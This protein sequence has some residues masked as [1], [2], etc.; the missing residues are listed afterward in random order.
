M[1][2]AESVR[3]AGYNFRSQ[4]SEDYG[5][6]GCKLLKQERVSSYVRKLR[7][8][9]FAKDALS[10]A[11]KRAFLARAVRS[12]ASNPD[13]DLVQE[14]VETHGEHGSSK[15]VKIVSK[16]EALNIDNK[17][18]GD[19]FRDRQPQASNPFLFIVSLGKQ[20]GDLSQGEAVALPVVTM[21]ASAPATI[22]IDA[23]IVE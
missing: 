14:V 21:P 16:L 6:Y 5:S 1:S 19:E 10:F 9:S 12:D 3:R 4:R 2:I 13:P 18:S 22:P 20:G 23:E 8:K 11:E 15:R 7:E 17:M